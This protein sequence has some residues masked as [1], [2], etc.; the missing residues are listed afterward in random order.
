MGVVSVNEKPERQGGVNR[1]GVYTAVKVYHVRVDDPDDDVATVILGTGIVPNQLHP[2]PQLPAI[3]DEIDAN[4][5]G[6]DRVDWEVVV[7]YTSD[8]GEDEK[9]PDNPLNDLPEIDWSSR[10]YSEVA[11]YDNFGVEILNSAL[12]PYEPP[13]EVEKVDWVVSY[14][15]NLG[16]V[17]SFLLQY[18]NAINTDPFIID[19]F[20]V[21]VNQGMIKGLRI[22]RREIR[23][24][25]PFRR[26]ALEVHLRED[27]WIERRVEMGD[28][29]LIDDQDPSQGWKPITMKGP[30]V[31]E[32]RG[33]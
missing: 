14:S 17:P 7:R 15:V 24:D 19:G 33:P 16:A 25:I 1:E 10:P 9:D 6:D 4:Q 2:D 29:A 8:V 30:P 18:E 32:T 12:R 26:V 13:I 31:F 11:E 27:T 3:V 23:N 20:P 21:D 28:E 5:T 22:G